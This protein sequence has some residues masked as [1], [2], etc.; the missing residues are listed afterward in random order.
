MLRIVCIGGFWNTF[1][2]NCIWAFFVYKVSTSGDL[3]FVQTPVVSLR[4][5][6][7]KDV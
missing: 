4:T 6:C 7:K 3:A 1:S 2:P 5:W